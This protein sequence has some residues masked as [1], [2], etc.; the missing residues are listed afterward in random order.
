MTAFSSAQLHTDG[1][2]TRTSASYG[3]P[4]DGSSDWFQ[5]ARIL[6]GGDVAQG[7]RSDAASIDPTA[8]STIIGLLK[9]LLNMVRVLTNS[10]STAQENDRVIKATPGTLYGLTVYNNNAAAQWIQLHNATSAPADGVVPAL[11]FAIAA[12]SNI[13]L[14]FTSNGRYFSTG[15][16][17]CTSTTDVTKTLGADDCL[18]DA[19]YL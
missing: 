7:D 14:T 15:I 13:A 17:V 11:T 18:F 5:I 9:G 12:Q 4:G 16:Y 10:T 3:D 19:Q 6:D 8:A 1:Q 2:N